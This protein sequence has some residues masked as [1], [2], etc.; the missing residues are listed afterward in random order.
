MSRIYYDVNGTDTTSAV[1]AALLNSQTYVIADLFR[2]Q[3]M[4]FWNGNAYGDY[5]DFVF[6]NADFPIFINKYQIGTSGTAQL[7][8]YSGGNVY[9][10][11]LTFSPE[12]INHPK[13]EYDVGFEAKQ[14]EIEWFMDD[15]KNYG[16]L[17]GSPLIAQAVV[18]M[19]TAISPVSLTLK[20]ALL[21]GSFDECPFWIHRAVFSDSPN[22][23]GIL[24]GTTLMLRGFIRSVEAAMDHV[25]ITVDSLLSIFQTTKLPVQTITPNTRSIPFY[26]AASAPP[27]GANI[28]SLTINSLYSITL[29]SNFG[30]FTWTR[31]ILKDCYISFVPFISGAGY[32]TAIFAPE[33][34]APAPT[35]RIAGNDAGVVGHCTLYFYKPPIIPPGAFFNI[36]GQFSYSSPGAAPGFLLVPPPE[37]GV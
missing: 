15:S 27:G 31:D 33:G 26:P 7:G 24:L 17:F 29:N 9:P 22:R 5:G 14:V 28:D 10:Q 19:N 2:F 23:G 3:A 11:G 20:Q 12:K 4:I 1:Q 35:F 8:P 13:L 18:P 25:K 21:L 37:F 32:P 6:T 30:T 16:V 36:F 34:K